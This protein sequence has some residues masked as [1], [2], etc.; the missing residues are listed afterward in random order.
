MQAWAPKEDRARKKK[1]LL[2]GSLTLMFA[3]DKETSQDTPCLLFRE[4]LKLVWSQAV[5]MN[6]AGAGELFQFCCFSTFARGCENIP[7]AY[8]GLRSNASKSSR[9]GVVIPVQGCLRWLGLFLGAC[10]YCWWCRL[11]PWWAPLPAPLRRPRWYCYEQ[12]YPQI[13]MRIWAL[14]RDSELC[15]IPLLEIERQPTWSNLGWHVNMDDTNS[16]LDI[17]L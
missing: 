15:F 7:T 5:Q 2:S 16:W 10:W 14:V 9:A 12:H 13:C 6:K 1:T 8:P 3:C 17:S 4:A 11:Y